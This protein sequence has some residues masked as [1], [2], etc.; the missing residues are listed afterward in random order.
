MVILNIETSATVCSVATAKDGATVFEKT[1]ID[2]PSHAQLLGVFVDEA[3]KDLRQQG[4]Q[5]DAVA[6]SSGP[7]SYTGLRIGVS[8]AK[9]LCFGLNVPLL[10]IPTLDLLAS[11][12]TCSSDALLCPM[13]DA[14]R[15]EVY[16]AIYD[17]ELHQVRSVEAEVV[18][19]DT[20]KSYLER[21]KVYFFGDGAEKCKSVIH[22]DNA[23]FIDGIQPLARLMT[24]LSAYA[25]EANRFED[26]AYFEPFYLKDFIA[27]IP[28]NKVISRK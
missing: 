24:P 14:R 17:A 3:L 5:L 19:S 12:A 1:S 20:Y 25:Y 10:S 16:S 21:G 13:I 18:T 9:G 28:K 23:V 27:T 8:M 2:G 6:V 22:S 26:V 15:M 11:S 4:I 7:G